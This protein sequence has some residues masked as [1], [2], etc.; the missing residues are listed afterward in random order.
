MIMMGESRVPQKAFLPAVLNYL[1]L[2]DNFLKL[3]FQK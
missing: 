2:K 3:L 1:T